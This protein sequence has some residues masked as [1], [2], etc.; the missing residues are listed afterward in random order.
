MELKNIKTKQELEEFANEL[1]GEGKE[2]EKNLF[3]ALYLFLKDFVVESELDLEHMLSLTLATKLPRGMR[4]PSSD[5]DKIFEQIAVVSSTATCLVYYNAFKL[6]PEGVQNQAAGNLAYKICGQ[7]SAW[8]NNPHDSSSPFNNN[9]EQS[10]D[11]W[12]EKNKNDTQKINTIKSEKD[13]N[14]LFIFD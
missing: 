1:I 4:N 2:C 8:P 10:V 7:L 11:S 6:Y 13:K 3:T 5:V 12:M 9:K 14:D